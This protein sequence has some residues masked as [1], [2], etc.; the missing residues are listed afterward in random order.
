MAAVFGER[1]LS[2]DSIALLLRGSV[3]CLY[4]G[5]V[6]SG[7]RDEVEDAGDIMRKEAS[8]LNDACTVQVVCAAMGAAR[9]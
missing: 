3:A 9:V 1:T 5:R 2:A 8:R 7:M 4:D 6:D